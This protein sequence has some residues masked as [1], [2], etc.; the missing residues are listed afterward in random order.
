MVATGFIA[1]LLQQFDAENSASFLATHT[2]SLHWD[3]PSMCCGDVQ[4]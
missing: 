2:L 4:T 1:L 3:V